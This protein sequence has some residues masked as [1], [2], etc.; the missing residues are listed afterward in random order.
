[1]KIKRILALALGFIALGLGSLGLF[2]PL[3]PTTPFVLLAAMCFSY[4]SDRFYKWLKSNPIFAPYIE[5]YME[6][7]GLTMAFKVKNIVILWISLAI[8]M[9]ILRN[10]WSY[11]LLCIVGICVTTH[12]LMIKTREA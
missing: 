4:S 9:F 10:T 11:V 7:R 5:N 12:L 3:L 6:K 2:L 8:S 1:M